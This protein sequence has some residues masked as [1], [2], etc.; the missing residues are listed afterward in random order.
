MARH[1]FS[2]RQILAG[3]GGALGAGLALGGARAAPAAAARTYPD[4]VGAVKTIDTK[5]SD[6]L[7][8]LARANNLGYVEIVAANPGVDPWIPGDGTQITLPTAHIL[9][10]APREGLV[11]N[12]A[13]LRLY[14]FPPGGAPLESFPIGIGDVGWKTPIGTTR[15]VRK[16]KNPTW[17]VPKS[18]MA[19]DPGHAKVVPPGPDNPL[20]HYAMYLGWPS[21]LIHGTNK[22]DGVGRRAS[23]GCVRLYPEAIASLFPRIAIGTPV[24]VVDQQAKFGWRKG[25]L[26]AQIHLSQAQAAEIEETGKFAQATIPDLAYRAME[27][28]G[29]RKDEIDWAKLNDAVRT[30]NGVLFRVLRAQAAQTSAR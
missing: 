17:H 13:E 10:D 6:T 7:L 28:A 4:I 5:A 19:E 23:H 29:P 24:S 1:D 15:V 22:P 25:E 8:D 21:Y 18:I 9:P 26:Y 30:R 12:L 2:R 27:A 16:Q 14:H 20:G 11:L 3:L